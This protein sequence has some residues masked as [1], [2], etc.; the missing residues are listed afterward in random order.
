MWKLVCRRGENSPQQVSTKG[1]EKIL[2]QFILYII[3]L[4]HL[5]KMVSLLCWMCLT[6]SNFWKA[7]SRSGGWVFPTQES[8]VQ[9]H[10]QEASEQITCD[11][12]IPPLTRFR[13]E[14]NESLKRF[15]TRQI[16]IQTFS[17]DSNPPN[18]DFMSTCS[19]GCDLF[20]S[21]FLQPCNV[22]IDEKHDS[23]FNGQPIER[24]FLLNS[25]LFWVLWLLN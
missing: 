20:P 18:E 4:L 2:Q 6:A 19:M 25:L 21:V 24:N 5:K 17:V 14:S 23:S 12:S 16:Y 7:S 22:Q 3:R 15:N 9:L 10:W 11:S 1:E 13:P 8:P